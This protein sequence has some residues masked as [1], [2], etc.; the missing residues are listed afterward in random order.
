[1]PQYATAN[2]NNNSLNTQLP[3]VL[4]PGDSLYLFGL[5]FIAANGPTPGQII[6]A[7]DSNVLPETAAANATS[8]AAAFA[9]R[10]GGG[11][12]PGASILVIANANPGVMEVDVQLSPM[13]SDGSY[14]LPTGSTTFKINTWTQM[15]GSTNWFAWAEFEPL[16]DFFARLKVITNP[17]AVKLTAKLN[18]V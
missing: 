5:S 3:S 9:P 18:Y 12:A 7:N 16:S 17:N 2:T 11:A 13:D 1:M 8:I 15:G 6:A 10:P 14:A 4:W